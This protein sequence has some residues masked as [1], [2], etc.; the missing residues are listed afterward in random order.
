MKFVHSWQYL[1]II[2]YAA[3]VV[4]NKRAIQF[5]EFDSVLSLVGDMYCPHH[6]SPLDHD[7]AAL[8]FRSCTR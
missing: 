8:Q 7:P 4:E 5:N 3:G 2:T 1:S 6:G